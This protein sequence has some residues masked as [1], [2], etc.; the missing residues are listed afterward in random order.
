LGQTTI[1]TFDA[2]TLSEGEALSLNGDWGFIWGEW[3]EPS[4]VVHR[5]LPFDVVAI[6]N[7]L[8]Q[9]APDSANQYGLVHGEASYFIRLLNL[10]TQFSR[11]AIDFGQVREAWKAYWVK[12]NGETIYLGQSGTLGRSLSEETLREPF[13]I[14]D[15][16]VDQREGILLIHLSA[17]HFDRSGLF[18]SYEVN[19][20]ESI[21][22]SNL[23]NLASRAF[24]VAVGV[25]IIIQNLVFYVHRR[26]EKLL[27]LLAMFAGISVIRASLASGYVDYFVTSA[28]WTIPFLKLEYLMVI[29]P[30]TAAV[31]YV[32]HVFPSK[33]SHRLTQVAY[34]VLAVAVV[35]TLAMP[36]TQ[37]TLALTYYQLA[38]LGVTS[39]AVY[40]IGQGIFKKE[41]DSRYFMISFVPLIIA[42]FNDIISAN[43]AGYNFY[44]AEYALFIFL[45]LQ[46]QLQ[47]SRFVQALDTAEHLTNNLQREVDRKT[48][49]LSLRNAEL[50]EKAIHLEEKHQE[51][52]LLSETDHLTGLYNR[53]T[54]ESHS[55]LLFEIAS[56]YE[57][58]L[59]VVMID[60]DHFKDINDQYGHLVGDECLVFVASY[61]RGFSLRKRD[62]IARYGGEEITII[63]TDTPL[64]SAQRIVQG[65]CDG[66]SELPIQGDHPDIYLTASFGIAD[67][68]TTGAK[69]IQ[70]LIQFADE[71]LY[72]A[73]E[74][75]RNRVEFYSPLAK[76]EHC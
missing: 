19:E 8:H 2:A 25:Y 1:P 5:A 14:L 23:V 21:L 10:D 29:W 32:G 43:S 4:A 20:Q 17:H 54:L 22:R 70:S 15:L 51:V 61:L 66:L 69:D 36:I 26:R 33:Y 65:I 64:A 60:L 24:L 73:K 55:K 53:Q 16:P 63:L 12:P 9:I 58:P 28:D 57:Q 34:G 3:V 71:A 18:S 45:F 72:R 27:L 56:A 42:V 37:I 52:K 62:I 48:Q 7:Y 31:H 67:I 68:D 75:G 6:P 41:K 35:F 50:E 30:A 44:I 38:L 13:Y 76:P 59:S 47:A 74:N 11:P 39:L 49:Q 46:T 40:Q